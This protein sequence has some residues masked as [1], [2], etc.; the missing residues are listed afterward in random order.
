[1]AEYRKDCKCRK[2][3]PGLIL[4]AAASLKL[5]TARSFTVGDRLEDMKTGRAAGT[6]NILV[7]SGYGRGE[8]EYVLPQSDVRPDYVAEDLCKAVDWILNEIKTE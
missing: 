1:V 5:D 2:P 4:E 3:R 8:L 6:R 7:L